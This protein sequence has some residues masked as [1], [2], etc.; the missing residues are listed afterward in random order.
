MTFP[1]QITKLESSLICFIEP[2]ELNVLHNEPLEV[3]QLNKRNIA[4]YLRNASIITRLAL[5]HSC[6]YTRTRRY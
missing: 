6:F 3:N 2:I 5:L 1:S 4:I